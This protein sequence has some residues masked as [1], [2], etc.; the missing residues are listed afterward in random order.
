[1]AS[2]KDITGYEGLYQ[3][4]DDGQIVSLARKG[5]RRNKVLKQ[6]YRGG[7]YKFV[8]LSRNGIEDRRGVHRLVAEAFLPNPDNLPEVNHKDENP[9]NNCVENLEWCTREYNIGYSKNRKVCQYIDG[10]IVAVH[11]SITHAARDSGI[12]RTSI[13]NALCGWTKTAGGYQWAYANE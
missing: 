11:D 10:R 9:E 13:N 2:W 7:R 12:G 8:V 1:M 5:R 4:S 3:V 6:G